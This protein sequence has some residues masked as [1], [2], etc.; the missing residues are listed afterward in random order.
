MYGLRTLFGDPKYFPIALI[1]LITAFIAGTSFEVN[2][3]AT[4]VLLVAIWGVAQASI[5]LI[6]RDA[7]SAVFA[8]ALALLFALVPMDIV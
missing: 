1:A 6:N 8:F 2:S 5:D 7:I 4:F 3:D